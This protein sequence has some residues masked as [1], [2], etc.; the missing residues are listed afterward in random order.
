MVEGAADIVEVPEQWK[1]QVLGDGKTVFIL[2]IVG[3][4]KFPR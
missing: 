3:P 1:G 4:G 2:S